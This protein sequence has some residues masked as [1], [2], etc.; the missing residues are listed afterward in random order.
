LSL[1]AEDLLSFFFLFDLRRWLC[2]SEM[3][4]ASSVLAHLSFFSFFFFFPLFEAL[5]RAA[6]SKLAGYRHRPEEEEVD[7]AP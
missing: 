5:G 6:S 7:S 1:A 4:Y 2:S 3:E